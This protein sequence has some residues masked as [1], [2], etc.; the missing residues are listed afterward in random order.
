VKNAQNWQKCLFRSTTTP[1]RCCQ[2]GLAS[3]VKGG[4][5]NVPTNEGQEQKS[6]NGRTELTRYFGLCDLFMV[7]VGENMIICTL[8]D[9]VCIILIVIYYDNNFSYL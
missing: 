1:V 7:R 6:C 8:R 4:R 5:V 2:L 9:R 3:K